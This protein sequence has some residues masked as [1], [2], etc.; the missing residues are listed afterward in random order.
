ME[1]FLKGLQ[2]FCP[3]GPPPTV[4]PRVFPAPPAPT[5][6]ALYLKILLGVRGW[7]FQVNELLEI[8]LNGGLGGR[9]RGRPEVPGGGTQPWVGYFIAVTLMTP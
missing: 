8:L 6:P 5:A 7:A 2:C 9:L 3:Q 1:S 4:A